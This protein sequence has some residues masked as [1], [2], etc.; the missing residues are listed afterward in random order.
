MEATK[1]SINRGMA[2]ESMAQIYTGILLSLKKEWNDTIC[3]N[4]DRPR[5]VHTKWSKSDRKRCIMQYHLYV[6]S[7]KSND[8]NELIYKIEAD[9]QI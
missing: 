7:K 3:S 8:I 5:D 1:M 4:M 6:K 9:S 2:K